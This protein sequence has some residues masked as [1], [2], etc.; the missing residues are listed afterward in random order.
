[1][2][3]VVAVDGWPDGADWR[4]I[5]DLAFSSDAPAEAGVWADGFS[6]FAATVANF[7]LLAAVADLNFVFAGRG[8]AGIT[9]SGASTAAILRRQPG[10]AHPSVATCGSVGQAQAAKVT[11]S[12]PT[13]SV[14]R[15]NGMAKTTFGTVRKQRMDQPHQFGVGQKDSTRHHTRTPIAEMVN[16]ARGQRSGLLH[17]KRGDPAAREIKS[18]SS[19]VKTALL[20]LGTG[21]S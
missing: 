20:K 18:P 10:E 4:V 21:S 14:R 5:E 1:M 3:V 11:D 7:G 8:G 2:V 9:S 16:R 15:Q 17:A 19:K 6:G 13:R 12:A